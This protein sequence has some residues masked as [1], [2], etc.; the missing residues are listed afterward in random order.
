[1]LTADCLGTLSCVDNNNNNNKNGKKEKENETHTHTKQNNKRQKG[2]E[3]RKEKKEK[4]KIFLVEILSC[5]ATDLHRNGLMDMF[6]NSHVDVIPF[7][8]LVTL[9]IYTRHYMC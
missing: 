6:S 7:L 2:K 4:T 8:V 3:K 1:M 9:N 5:D